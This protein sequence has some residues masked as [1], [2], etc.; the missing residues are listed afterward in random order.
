MMAVI[1][2]PDFRPIPPFA[3]RVITQM[4]KAIVGRP[5]LKYRLLAGTRL[6]QGR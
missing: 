6:G 2:H 3:R 1:S 5:S 4:A